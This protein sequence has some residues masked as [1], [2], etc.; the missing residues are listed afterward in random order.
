METGGTAFFISQHL[1]VTARSCVPSLWRARPGIGLLARASQARVPS[2]VVAENQDR[3]IALLEVGAPV[4]GLVPL[5]LADG[6]P[7]PHLQE[8][9][10]PGEPLVSGEGVVGIATAPGGAAPAS[11]IRDLVSFYTRPRDAT[12]GPARVVYAAAAEGLFLKGLANRISPALKARLLELGLDLD[13]RLRPTYPRDAWIQMLA[14]AVEELFP[15]L[16]AEEGYRKLGEASIQGLARTAIG[17][18]VMFI[19]RWQAPRRSLQRLREGFSAVNNFMKV[20]MEDLGPS[21]FRMSLNETYGC[22]AYLQGA[23]HAA[24]IYAGAQELQVALQ[25]ATASFVS[26][27]V[28]WREA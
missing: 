2:Q 4:A 17:R 5:S 8:A 27:D 11:A 21:H 6:E 18:T 14:A 20:E 26:L 3:S 28:R 1:A 10:Q 25:D 12:P 15:E 7:A 9:L 22:P 16:P 24:M 13:Q 23:I 19:A